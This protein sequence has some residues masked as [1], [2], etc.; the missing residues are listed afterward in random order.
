MK[1]IQ[2]SKHT[3]YPSFDLLKIICAILVVAAH[4]Q[5]FKEYNY[6]H[7]LSIHIEEIAIPTFFSISGFLFLSKIDT[8]KGIN[9][10]KILFLSIK[11]LLIIFTIWY[12]LMIPFTIKGFFLIANIKEI[13]Y[14]IFL[15]CSYTGY[16][17]LK[18]LIANTIIIYLCRKKNHLLYCL[19]ISICIQLSLALNYK[20]HY[21]SLPFSPYFSFYYHT[22]YYALGA[23]LA[24][25]YTSRHCT[26]KTYKCYLGLLL[27]FTLS[28][29]PL[30][31]DLCRLIYPIILILFFS[32]STF[33]CNKYFRKISILMYCSHFVF[34]DLYNYLKN[35][36]TIDYFTY[37]FNHSIFEF[38]FVIC[39]VLCFSFI[40][41]KLEQKKQFELLKYLH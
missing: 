39:C 40:I 10:K 30:I 15:S 23:F 29:L 24:R 28:F 9:H 14:A 18:A 4:T 17:F 35:K 31:H 37:I 3:Y 19:T 7:I 38:I 8:E 21:I 22:A 33:K 6:I 12:I 27:I 34:I 41:I 11:R 5:L 1:I 32:Q 13:V 36:I 26:I 20:Y 25:I 2:I 16:W